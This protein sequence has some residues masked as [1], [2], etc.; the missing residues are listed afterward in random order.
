MEAEVGV[1]PTQPRMPRTAGHH[2][3][4]GGRQGADPPLGAPGGANPADTST[5]GFGSQNP[6]E[7][8][9]CCPKPPVFGSSWGQ[10]RGAGI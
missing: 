9:F 7:V 1:M 2:Q 6:E 8:G 3:R 10:L 5:S 4:L